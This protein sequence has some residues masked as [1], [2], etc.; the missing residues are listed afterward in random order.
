[1]KSDYTDTAD[2]LCKQFES[3]F[4][5]E[6]AVESFESVEVQDSI[7]VKFEELT[8]Y[9]K[10]IALKTNKSLGS[11]S[12]HPM[13]L[14][15]TAAAIANSQTS[16]ST[17]QLFIYRTQV[18]TGLEIG[19]MLSSCQFSKKGRRSDPENYR[20]I[21]LTSAICKIM[22]SVIRD[23]ITE[24]I[25]KKNLITHHQH[26]F[27][28]GRSCL[29]NLLEALEAWTSIF[30]EGY[31]LDI[32]Y[33]DYRKAFDTVPHRK[34]V[35]KL[36]DYGLPDK[37]LIW[38]NSSLQGRMMKV[39][40]SGSSS[41]Y[42][43]LVFGSVNWKGWTASGNDKNSDELFLDIL[44]KKGL[45]QHVD[46][47][48]RQIGDDEPSILILVTSRE[49]LSKLEYLSPLGKSDFDFDFDFDDVWL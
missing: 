41:S 10:L 15:K 14:S 45:M 37:L 46:K 36:R 38:L 23:C 28:S 27:I 4:V 21:S 32:I 17:V 49:Y 13:F 24:F 9:K 33:L 29:R 48:T 12:I 26:G 18:T 43:N 42:D 35:T 6:T 8:I 39:Q 22:E 25:Q 47:P 19:K 44:T 31:G 2:V 34:L 16:I 30:D 3:V 40:V 20:P 7:Y 1:M 5:K 11:D